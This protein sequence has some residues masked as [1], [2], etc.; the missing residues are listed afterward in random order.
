MSDHIVDKGTEVPRVEG[1]TP[2]PIGL[3]SIEEEKK[4]K[5]EEEQRRRKEEK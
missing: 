2:W 1:R 3:H 5:T 4:K